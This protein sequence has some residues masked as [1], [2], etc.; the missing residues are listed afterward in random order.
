[1][2]LVL[3]KWNLLRFKIDSLLGFESDDLSYFSSPNHEI[4]AKSTFNARHLMYFSNYL[5]LSESSGAIG[6][7][8]F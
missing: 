4:D 1:M 2:K 5:S 7:S 3:D 6:K 8:N